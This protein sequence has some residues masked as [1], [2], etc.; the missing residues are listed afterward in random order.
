MSTIDIETL[1][2]ILKE[3]SERFSLGLFRGDLSIS[4][5]SGLVLVGRKFRGILARSVNFSGCDLTDCD[6][7][8][9]KLED[10]DFSGA[11]LSWANFSYA[12]LDNVD[13]SGAKLFEANLS[14]MPLD[15]NVC[16]DGAD[17]RGVRRNLW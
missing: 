16:F 8:Y 15:D 1:D 4:D 11:N 2:R 3:H 12:H 5:L 14:Y 17:M 13:F 6:F 7:S 9:C 10:S